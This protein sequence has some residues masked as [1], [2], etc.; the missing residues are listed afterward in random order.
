MKKNIAFVSIFD[1]TEV[2]YDIAAR[3]AERGHNIFWITTNEYW[4]DWLVSQGVLRTNILELVYDKSDF[5]DEAEKTLLIQQIVQTEA[6]TDL[7]IN[8]VLQM[9]QFVRYKNK[10]DI[11][12]YVL[13]YYRYIKRFLSDKRVSLVFAEPTN[14]NEMITYMICREL[15]IPFLAPRDM[16]YPLYRVIFNEGYLQ[17]EVISNCHKGESVSGRELL[18]QFLFRRTTPYYFAKNSQARA[19]DPQKILRSLRNRIS[20]IRYSRRNLTH[21]DLSERCQYLAKRVVNGF[22]LRHLCRYTDLGQIHGRV[23]FYPLHVQPES[24]IDVLGS[25]FS[26]QLK[27]IKDIRRALPFDVTLV[28]KEHP[29]FLGI[30]GIGFFRQVRRIPNVKLVRHNVSNFD[31]YKRSS[32]VFTVSGTPAYEA[33]M[34]GVP[35][36]TFTRMYFDGLSSVRCC[37]D[38][39]QLKPLVFERLNGFK[40]DYEAD[41]RFMADLVGRSYEGLWT[42]PRFD[43]RVLDPTNIEKL[44]RAFVKVVENDS[45]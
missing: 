14:T 40:R 3:L 27:L 10:R 2:F 45:D 34:L 39:A 20:R 7:N 35:A 11:N 21:H 24:S 44:T 25:Y 23:G 19:L 43:P 8:Q 28:V 1:L 41:C 13:L 12:E 4:T 36:V 6:A 38:I 18:D 9:D 22:Y 32:I 30:K 31:I 42:D 15:S 17:S 37:T 16:R 33:G 26:D 5:V 29:N